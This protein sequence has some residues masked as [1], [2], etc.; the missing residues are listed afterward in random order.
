MKK[1][2]AGKHEYTT[3]PLY[4][5]YLV[6]EQSLLAPVLHKDAV[7]LRLNLLGHIIRSF[8]TSRSNPKSCHMN[9]MWL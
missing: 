1:I 8:L 7:G 2:S 3:S 6:K 4:P 9:F 5:L